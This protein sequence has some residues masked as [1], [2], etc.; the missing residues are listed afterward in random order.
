MDWINGGAPVGHLDC[1]LGGCQVG[2]HL[3]ASA[4]DELDLRL[5]L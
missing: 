3:I 1:R 2:S 4:F 5:D